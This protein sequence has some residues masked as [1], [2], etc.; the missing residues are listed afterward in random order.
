MW[1]NSRFRSLP[2]EATDPFARE[3]VSIFVVA[4]ES[5]D[6]TRPEVGAPETNDQQASPPVAEA[7]PTAQQT[8]AELESTEPTPAIADNNQ[9]AAT[10]LQP[11]RIRLGP[12]AT[13]DLCG[14]PGRE[15]RDHNR[16]RQI[17]R[18]SGFESSYDD[19]DDAWVYAEFVR[20]AADISACASGDW[21][22][23]ASR[24]RG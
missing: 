22:A 17:P 5:D 20:P 14:Q 16:R 8:G 15:P 21:T 3:D 4:E 2:K 11:A 18:E 6:S 1:E 7:E 9:V 19:H 12:G 10:M 24:G 13:Y 23:A